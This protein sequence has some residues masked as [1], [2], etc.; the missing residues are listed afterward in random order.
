MTVNI[1]FSTLVAGEISLERL[2]AEICLRGVD[3]VG[4]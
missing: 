1:E 4:G 3:G 2:E